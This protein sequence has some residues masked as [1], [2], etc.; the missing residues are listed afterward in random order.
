M[1]FRLCRPDAADRPLPGS[2]GAQLAF[3]VLVVPAEP[4]D[5]IV[6]KHEPLHVDLVESGVLE[7][8]REELRE[9]VEYLEIGFARGR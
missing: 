3:L 4:V 2:H 5:P 8:M 1:R 7:T 9:P 6:G